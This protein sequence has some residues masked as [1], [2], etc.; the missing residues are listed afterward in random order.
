VTPAA[1]RELLATCGADHVAMLC[2]FYVYGLGSALLIG[3]LELPAAVNLA[4]GIWAAGAI[5]TTTVAAVAMDRFMLSARE[6]RLPS[7][8][9]VLLRSYA[10][11]LGLILI[12]PI[13]LF[14]IFIP[15][16]R[17]LVWATLATPLGLLWP[18][19]M[20]FVRSFLPVRELPRRDGRHP[21]N[22]SPT[23]TIRMYIG[24]AFA[25]VSFASPA[26]KL[27]ILGV[28]LW[29]ATFVLT[30]ASARP[31]AAQWYLA[32]TA[33]LMWLWFMN[34]LA[35]FIQNRAASFSELALLPG[36]GHPRSQ[37]WA[38]YRATLAPPLLTCSVLAALSLILASRKSD[39]ADEVLRYG[40]IL[41]VVL[42]VNAGTVFAQLFK[43]GPTRL[44]RCGLLLQLSMS[45]YIGPSLLRL[46][47]HLPGW[48][49]YALLATVFACA[50]SLVVVTWMHARKLARLPHPFLDGAM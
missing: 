2:I 1:P 45:I 47:P 27:R 6:L 33:I 35:Q 5:A 3:S 43:K 34:G 13:V 10:L 17:E 19:L 4:T 44:T 21:S 11:L 39:A 18:Q 22:G 20:R 40:L 37:R 31:W 38:L 36:L 12:V 26:F 29:S 24:R 25:P 14:R 30:A 23:E 28:L 7:Y 41:L 46:S 48:F 8:G 15:V 49:T 42:L 16:G 9:H 50:A 32:V